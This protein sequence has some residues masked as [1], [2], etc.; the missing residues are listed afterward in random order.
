MLLFLRNVQCLRVLRWAPGA[1]EPQLL[2][3]CSVVVPPRCSLRPFLFHIFT[4]NNNYTTMYVSCEFV[5]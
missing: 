5:I 1:P 4:L 3:S 2:H